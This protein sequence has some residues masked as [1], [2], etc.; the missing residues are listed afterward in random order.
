MAPPA[1]RR[2][3]RCLCKP[4]NSQISKSLRKTARFPIWMPGFVPKGLLFQRGYIEDYANG[5]QNV[6]LFYSALGD[7]TDINLKTMVIVMSEPGQPISLDSIFHQFKVTILDVR[8]IQV[9]GQEGFSYW[10]PCGACNNSAVL[11][12]REDNVDFRITLNGN[13]PAPDDSHPH[14]LDAVLLLIAE[15]LKTTP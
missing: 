5:S 11:F 7:Q 14:A 15:G 12:W 1:R 9:R 2:S 13:W 10:T 3:Q 6:E 4:W 8:E